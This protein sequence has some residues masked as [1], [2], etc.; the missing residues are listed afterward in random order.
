MLL[1]S[2][3]VAHPT[4]S[5]DPIT[6]RPI[7]CSEVNRVLHRHIG[8]LYGGKID[9]EVAAL[10]LGLLSFMQLN[11]FYIH[12]RLQLTYS[13]HFKIPPLILNQLP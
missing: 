1:K 9:R 6:W 7:T 10:I 13:V 4:I 3:I 11:D 5:A 12:R 2:L 8:R